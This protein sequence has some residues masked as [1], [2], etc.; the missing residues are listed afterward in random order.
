MALPAGA[1]VAQE[2]ASAD[3]LSTAAANVEIRLGKA[4]A[5]RIA[6]EVAGPIIDAAS[7]W[8]DL[9][10]HLAAEGIQYRQKGS[11]AVLYIGDEI[12]KASTYR[13]AA[14]G[15]LVKRLGPFE[16]SMIQ[17]TPR[18]AEPAP[19]VA[20]ELF[21]AI[22][23]RKT[24]IAEINTRAA[25]FTA[26]IAFAPKLAKIIGG[27]ISTNIDIERLAYEIGAPAP[28]LAPLR[29]PLAPVH[30]PKSAFGRYHANVD[31]Q[32]YRL[33]FIKEA[34]GA[35]PGKAFFIPFSPINELALHEKIVG[36]MARDRAQLFIDPRSDNT[37]HVV[38][39]GL[40]KSNLGR[41]ASD[42]FA[43]ALVTQLAPDRFE[44]LIKAPREGLPHSDDAKSE[45]EDALNRQYGAGARQSHRF[46][47]RFPGTAVYGVDELGAPAKN[48]VRII[49]FAT[50]QFCAKLGEMIHAQIQAIETRLRA[51]SSSRWS[52]PQTQTSSATVAAGVQAYAAHFDDIIAGGGSRIHLSSVD[53][54]IAVQL[55]ATGHAR[56]RVEG[57]IAAVAPKT[58][59]ARSYDW[60]YYAQRMAD[61]AFSANS[62]AKAKFFEGDVAH[63]K[64]VESTAME[65][66]QAHPNVKREHPKHKK[67]AAG[68]QPTA[69]QAP[70]AGHDLLPVGERNNI[71]SDVGN[72]SRGEGRRRRKSRTTR[73]RRDDPGR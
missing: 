14:L 69:T 59:P 21:D 68:A 4:S 19:G 36:D 52:Q 48:V 45:V 22:E 64:H 13:K 73:P 17:A 70:R 12:V 34:S 49:K 41:I 7:S 71:K 30:D 26:P 33:I 27:T 11:G 2:I 28:V 42:G 31:A 58:D 55:R 24:E 60:A 35:R 1:I 10:A 61:Y 5:E 8:P 25:E 9:H 47:Q 62:R 32:E 72:P 37:H 57:I 54:A 3:A 16:P 44:V 50:R 51:L 65:V 56:E 63:W 43:P 29:Q 66:V 39:T 23:K 38:I 46:G 20:P 67:K 18:P 53:A 40:T 6:I 15:A